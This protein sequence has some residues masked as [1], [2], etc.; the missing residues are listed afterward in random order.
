MIL[1]VHDIVPEL[2]ASKFNRK[3]GS[4]YV[5]ALKKVERCSCDF[6]D[7]VIVSN[8]LW[9]ETLTRRSVAPQKCS[10]LINH[11]DT[12]VFQRRPR[13]RQDGRFIIVFPG[14]F[15]WHQGLDLAIE[16]FSQV[17]KEVPNAEFHIY[18]GGPEERSLIALTDRL[19]LN[20]VVKFCGSRPLDEMAEV[21]ANADL[22]VVPK[23][24]NSFGNEA[25]STKIME[26]MSQGV[27]VVVSN[28]KID[29]FYFRD[30]EVCFFES[31][32]AQSL[33]EAMLHVINSE[34]L[35]RSM[36]LAGERYVRQNGWNSKKREYLDLVD[37]L[38]VEKFATALQHR[39][40][41]AGY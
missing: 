4:F 31:G 28:T 26:F 25:Y 33:A 5:E 16:A 19:G 30:D 14:S 9:Q 21:I 13:T 8:H 36:I 17:R 20:G 39:T 6:V 2:F 1:D 10:V 22:G 15:Q 35:R 7:H 24:A 40:A 18:G 29:R 32:N 37:S 12:D 38:T 34:E 27:P 11:V 23:R 41:E 3:D